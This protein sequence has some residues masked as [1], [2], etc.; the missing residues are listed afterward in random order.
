MSERAEDYFK[1]E[2]FVDYFVG[3]VTNILT[4]ND[5]SGCESLTLQDVSNRVKSILLPHPAI[6]SQLSVSEINEMK[7][8]IYKTIET[9]F[10]S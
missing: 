9:E 5:G 4:E 2:E 8:Q 7:K 3:V 10:N 1:D 6:E